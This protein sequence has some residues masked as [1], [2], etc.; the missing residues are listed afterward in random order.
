M[1]NSTIEE[2]V[3][4]MYNESNHN[5]NKEIEKELEENW[6][7]REKYNV[8]KE[9]AERLG[10]M[11]LHS[12]RKQTIESIMKYANDKLNIPSR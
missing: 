3:L 1:V 11:K 10:G 9:S 2:L 8:I 5:R 12:P 7:L 6:V 4:Y